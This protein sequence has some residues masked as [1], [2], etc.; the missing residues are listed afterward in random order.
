MGKKAEF[1]RDKDQ[2]EKSCHQEENAVQIICKVLLSS[3]YSTRTKD[4]PNKEID[5][6]CEKPEDDDKEDG[7]S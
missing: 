1:P 7:E 6:D 5:A 3:S 4:L 2:T